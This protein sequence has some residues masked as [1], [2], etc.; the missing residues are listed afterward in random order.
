V[1]TPAQV[2]GLVYVRNHC[3]VP[4]GQSKMPHHSIHFMQAWLA[5]QSSG[6]QCILGGLKCV[7]PQLFANMQQSNKKGSTTACL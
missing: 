5:G 3:G 4:Y 2:C 6:I 1:R 7:L